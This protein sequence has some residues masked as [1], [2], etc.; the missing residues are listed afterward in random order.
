MEPASLRHP[1]K[2]ALR[3]YRT[4]RKPDTRLGRTCFVA[5]AIGRARGDAI[6]GA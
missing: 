1:T 3:G 6:L 4:Q 2:L 5:R